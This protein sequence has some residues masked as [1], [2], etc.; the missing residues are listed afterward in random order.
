[1]AHTSDDQIGSGRVRSVQVRSYISD[2]VRTRSDHTRSEHTI[3]EHTRSEHTIAEHTRSEHTRSEDQIRSDQIPHTSDRSYNVIKYQIISDQ[4]PHASDIDQIT[5]YY[6]ISEIRSPTHWMYS[7]RQNKSRA[8]SRYPY[9]AYAIFRRGLSVRIFLGVR[10]WTNYGAPMILKP[11]ENHTISALF[12]RIST[13][14]VANVIA[15]RTI[16]P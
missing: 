9:N 8:R 15:T 16:S 10:F 2:Q 6:C 1:M 11:S 3:V 14:V 12:R 13:A 5:K 7:H 4:I